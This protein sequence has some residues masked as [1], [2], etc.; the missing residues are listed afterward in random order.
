MKGS[1]LRYD[2]DELFCS[3]ALRLDLLGLRARSPWLVALREE[4]D[5]FLP[6]HR[7]SCSV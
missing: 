2:S 7:S 4:R 1:T 3:R 5:S 6:R